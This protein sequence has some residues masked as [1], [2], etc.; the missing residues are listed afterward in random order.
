MPSG[1]SELFIALALL[2]VYLSSFVDWQRTRARD[3]RPE[4][5]H[6]RT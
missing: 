4:E 1:L 5:N 2:S 3:D 6:G